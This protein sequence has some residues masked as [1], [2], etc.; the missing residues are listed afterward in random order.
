MV[1]TNT[2][3]QG[4]QNQQTY[5]RTF[6]EALAILEK[7]TQVATVY[8]GSTPTTAQL[9]TAWQ[10][11]TGYSDYVPAFGKVQW[12][13]PNR[14]VI[15]NVFLP[16]NDLGTGLSSGNFFSLLD[17]NSETDME[18]IEFWYLTEQAAGVN[19]KTITIPNTYSH[20]KL[21]F[22]IKSKVNGTSENLSA[23]VNGDTG[24]NYDQ[25][26]GLVTSPTA[27]VANSQ[28]LGTTSGF[29]AVAPGQP[30]L[31]TVDR[32]SFAFGE[33]DIPQ[34]NVTKT[35]HHLLLRAYYN[36]GVLPANTETLIWGAIQYKVSSVISSIRLFETTNFAAGSWI[37][38]YG[39]K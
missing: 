39:I 21:Y 1:F 13:N 17:K 28:S 15:E 7:D 38:A 11:N 16:I 19:T 24:A 35:T 20:F 27:S 5:I 23:Q 8:N 4:L 37:L 22:N 9:Q 12:Y 31:I 34:Y 2:W 3:Q 25:S 30:S 18:L 6:E 32:N 26:Y 33:I 14:S 10:A 29:L 36:P